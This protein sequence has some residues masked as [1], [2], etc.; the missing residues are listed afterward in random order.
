MYCNSQQQKM[1]SQNNFRQKDQH[2]V[3]TAERKKVERRNV[4][5]WC[6]KVSYD[7]KKIKKKTI[8]KSSKRC[9]VKSIAC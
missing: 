5:Y 1:G 7:D 8:E 3:P 6:K 9:G 2:D 4:H